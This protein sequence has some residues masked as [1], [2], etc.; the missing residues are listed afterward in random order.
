MK[1]PVPSPAPPCESEEPATFRRTRAVVNNSYVGSLH[2][3]AQA[4]PSSAATSSST[5]SSTSAP[6][7]SSAARDINVAAV[8][9]ALAA[10]SAALSTS[11]LLVA[12]SPT[13]SPSSSSQS[14]RSLLN[15]GSFIDDFIC[16]S[17]FA[18]QHGPVPLL[19]VPKGGER[20]FNLSNY[21][22]RIMAANYQKQ[23]TCVH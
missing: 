22:V 4:L 23:G 10:S 17:E 15:A 20:G 3:F 8:S 12:A 21:V 13:P 2:N 1:K 16:I 14:L 19:V 9:V 5:L 7:L 18:E 11:P 6:N